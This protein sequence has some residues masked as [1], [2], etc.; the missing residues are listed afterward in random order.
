MRVT[1]LVLSLVKSMQAILK[2]LLRTFVLCTTVH[3]TLFDSPTDGNGSYNVLPI[4][5]INFSILRKVNCSDPVMPVITR[6]SQP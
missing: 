1:T 5:N 3:S 6:V 2:H 4:Q